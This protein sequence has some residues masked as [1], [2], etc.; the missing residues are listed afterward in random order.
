MLAMWLI[1]SEIYVHYL[2]KNIYYC[3]FVNNIEKNSQIWKLKITI[4]FYKQEI[5]SYKKL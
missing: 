5:I 1:Y 4:F 3:T 2:D